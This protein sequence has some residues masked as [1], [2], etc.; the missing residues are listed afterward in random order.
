MIF[1]SGDGKTEATCYTREKIA[2]HCTGRVKSRWKLFIFLASEE[3]EK[4]QVERRR[5]LLFVHLPPLLP[6]WL[7]LVFGKGTKKPTLMHLA[8]LPTYLCMHALAWDRGEGKSVLKQHFASCIEREIPPRSPNTLAKQSAIISSRLF[9][10]ACISAY[11][12]DC[13][14]QCQARLQ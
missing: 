7:G 3:E 9:G 5:V 10:K 14:E 12:F 8:S 6:L 1:F 11:F 13:V 4:E 2:S